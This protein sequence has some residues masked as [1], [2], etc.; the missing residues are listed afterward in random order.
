MK[1]NKQAASDEI[2]DSHKMQNLKEGQ[3]E[4]ITVGQVIHTTDLFG[5]ALFH[6]VFFGFR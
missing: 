3:E 6:G 5:V 1:C 2:E 4:K